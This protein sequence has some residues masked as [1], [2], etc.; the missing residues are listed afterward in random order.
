M[1]LN[2][3]TLVFYRNLNAVTTGG[4]SQVYVG[5]IGNNG[6]IDAGGYLAGRGYFYID[7]QYVSYFDN[8]EENRHEMM[9]TLA[10]EYMHYTQDYY[11]T[12]LLQN[13]YWIRYSMWELRHF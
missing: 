9:R 13:Y 12:V 4:G 5:L 10:H 2:P 6:M 7:P 8:Q 3:Y 1:W 11:M